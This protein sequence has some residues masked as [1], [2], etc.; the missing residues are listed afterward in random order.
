MSVLHIKNVE[1]FKKEVLESGKLAVVDFRAER[2]G[3]CRM[4]GPII[5]Q[6]AEDHKDV[7]IAKVNVDENQELSATF[8]VSSIPVVFF[9]K[10]GKVVDKIVGANPPTVYKER[11]AEYSKPEKK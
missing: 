8:Q 3:P 6:L 7:V 2:C 11:I 9:V 1:E 5:E 4:L 10:D